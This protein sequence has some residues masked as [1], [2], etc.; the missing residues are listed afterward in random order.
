MI[1]F[2]HIFALDARQVPIECIHVGN[3]IRKDLGDIRLLAASIEAIGLLNPI[4]VAT[5]GVLLAGHR[6][7]EACRYL[8]WE[9]VPVNVRRA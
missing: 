4:T 3:R 2:N 1:D 6:R 8:G 7:L 5:S 9:E